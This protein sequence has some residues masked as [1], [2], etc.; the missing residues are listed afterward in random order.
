MKKPLLS[1]MIV[2]TLAFSAL[3]ASAAVSGSNPRPAAVSGSNPRPQAVSAPVSV[4]G[5]MY[6][7]VLAYFGF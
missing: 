1:V 3:N 7:A 5:S 2:V 6:I 4:L